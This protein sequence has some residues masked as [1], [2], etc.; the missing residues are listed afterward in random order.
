MM[1]GA[2]YSSPPSPN[3]GG[4]WLLKTTSDLTFDNAKY[5][6]RTALDYSIG[7][8]MMT[9]DGTSIFVSGQCNKNVSGRTSNLSMFKID[10][11]FN[12]IA[13]QKVYSTSQ[14]TVSANYGQ[15]TYHSDGYLYTQFRLNGGTYSKENSCIIKV[16][17]ST[18]DLVFARLYDGTFYQQE[19]NGIAVD[20]TNMY[21]ANVTWSITAG[22]KNTAGM[23]ANK[24]DGAGAGTSYTYDTNT[25]TYTDITSTFTTQ[26]LAATIN[27]AQSTP[28][29]TVSYT[30]S[31][32]T[33]TVSDATAGTWQK[34]NF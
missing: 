28:N 9:T 5:I 26:D 7:G 17:A 19:E 32:P 14:G 16:N 1:P 8:Q 6:A 4:A 23:F 27:A 34:V 18:G 25:W 11:G 10:T 29:N 30:Q 2:G 31:T 21:T 13:W 33:V 24:K 3:I 15:L 22:V 12:A 20:A